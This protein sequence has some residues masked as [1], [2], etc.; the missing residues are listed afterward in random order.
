MKTCYNP[1]SQNSEHGLPIEKRDREV[2]WSEVTGQDQSGKFSGKSWKE[3]A[4]EEEGWGVKWRYS[5]LTSVI[6]RFNL[7]QD[8]QPQGREGWCY[9]ILVLYCWGD[10]ELMWKGLWSGVWGYGWS[11]EGPGRGVISFF[12][13]SRQKPRVS[14]T[15]DVHTG[16]TVRSVRRWPEGEEPLVQIFLLCFTGCSRRSEWHSFVASLSSSPLSQRAH[17]T[18]PTLENKKT[19][20]NAPTNG[21]VSVCLY[22]WTFGLGRVHSRA[23]TRSVLCWTSQTLLLPWEAGRSWEGHPGTTSGETA[24]PGWRHLADWRAGRRGP[25]AS[26]AGCCQTGVWWESSWSRG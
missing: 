23:S 25:G 1:L 8:R 11:E 17:L 5:E 9:M 19:K 3:E 20:Q 18:R 10:P 16:C 14:R 15:C 13:N 2:D 24:V 26:R 21:C 4:E 12:K 7:T 22:P 6:R